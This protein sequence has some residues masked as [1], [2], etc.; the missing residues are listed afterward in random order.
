MKWKIKEKRKWESKQKLTLIYKWRIFNKI[1]IVNRIAKCTPFFLFPLKINHNS[2]P[3]KKILPKSK[4]P[5]QKLPPNNLPTP[6]MLASSASKTIKNPLFGN[7]GWLLAKTLLSKNHTLWT[8]KKNL[9][10]PPL[11]LEKIKTWTCPNPFT[12]FNPLIL[13]FLVTS[14]L[15]WRKRIPI[16]WNK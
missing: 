9:N 4:H 3:N 8:T 12:K 6:F 14:Y 10:S 7:L 13:Q 1:L 16:V 5:W 2:T 15:L 11:T